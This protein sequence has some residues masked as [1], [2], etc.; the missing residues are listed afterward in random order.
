[1]HFYDW[2]FFISA[3]HFAIHFSYYFSFHIAYFSLACHSAVQFSYYFS[4]QFNTFHW[5]WTSKDGHMSKNGHKIA[6]KIRENW[7]YSPG[8]TS[9]HSNL[10]KNSRKIR[11][12]W[13]TVLIVGDG[14][15]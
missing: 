10:S 1:M 5:W 9:K 3:F 15:G 7:G 4:L 14:V 6:E 11:E 8:Q 13:G 12:N 2:N